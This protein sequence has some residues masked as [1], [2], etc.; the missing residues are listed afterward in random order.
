MSR[1]DLINDII[2][3]ALNDKFSDSIDD[4]ETLSYTLEDGK[5]YTD[6]FNYIDTTVIPCSACFIGGTDYAEF[7]VPLSNLTDQS[8]NDLY[9][10]ISK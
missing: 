10:C 2:D 9:D 5:T 4:L 3:A 7:A 8:L 6:R 1:T